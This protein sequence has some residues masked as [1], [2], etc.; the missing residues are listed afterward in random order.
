M[1]RT[2]FVDGLVTTVAG[3]AASAE[4]FPLTFRMIP[5][6]D[7]VSFPG[8]YGLSAILQLPKPAS[9][10]RESV[11]YFR[12]PI[13][14]ECN[15][16]PVNAGFLFRFDE[17]KGDRKGYDRLIVDMNHSAFASGEKFNAEPPQPTFKVT[18]GNGKQVAEGTLEFG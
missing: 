18:D 15:Q 9:L 14:A 7:V 17:S 5:A 11:A 3:L 6:K 4:D 16:T 13:D 1:I 10:K 2:A 12:H 8:G